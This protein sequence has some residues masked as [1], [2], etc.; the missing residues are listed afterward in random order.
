MLG[1][2]MSNTMEHGHSLLQS[3]YIEVNRF[4]HG[5][6]YN[7]LFKYSMNCFSNPSS[8][9]KFDAEKGTLNYDSEK[10]CVNV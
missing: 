6:S 4:N 1:R 3:D 10:L 9:I 2:K 8:K 5:Q 7:G